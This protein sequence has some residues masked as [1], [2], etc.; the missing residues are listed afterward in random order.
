MLIINGEAYDWDLQFLESVLKL[1]DSH[2]EELDRSSREVP[3]PDS[4]GVFDHYEEV[5]GIGFVACQRYLAAI[6]GSLKL[7]KHT[8]LAQ[9]ARMACGFTVARAVNHAANYWKHHDEW[10][11]VEGKREL[12]TRR[13]IESFGGR[14]GV[15]YPLSSVLAGLTS[16]PHRL[17]ALLGR[18]EAWREEIRKNA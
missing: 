3:D 5:C 18:L 9:G 4:W 8:A 11:P 6:Y 12:D 1:L 15:D 2:L 10:P 7:E 13:A 14:I 16:K 17:G